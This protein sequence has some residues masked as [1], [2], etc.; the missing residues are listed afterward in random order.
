MRG[1]LPKAESIQADAQVEAVSVE[2]QQELLLMNKL[3][4]SGK[5]PPKSAGSFLQK[6]LQQ[7]KFFDSGDYNM[8][9]DKKTTT[10]TTNTSVV[11]QQPSIPATVISQAPPVVAPKLAATIEEPC[12]PKHVQQQDG[13]DSDI[14]EHLQIPRPDTV[15]QRKSSILHPSAHSKLSPQPHIHHEHTDES[16]TMPPQ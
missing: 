12:L 13:G 7:R 5:L 3:A 10:T 4:S 8:N 9:K 15:P 16:I 6:R 11:P 14:D 1:D 2:K